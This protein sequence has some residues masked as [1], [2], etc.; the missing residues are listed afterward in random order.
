MN[1]TIRKRKIENGELYSLRL[2]VYPPVL[3]PETGKLVR[4]IKLDMRLYVAPKTIEE[5]QENKDA[6][7]LAKVVRSKTELE[8]QAGHYGFLLKKRDLD[9][10]DFYRK[11]AEKRCC[12]SNLAHNYQSSLGKFLLFVK[13]E[14]FTFSQITKTFIERYRAFLLQDAGLQHNTAALYFS[15]FRTVLNDA[16][17]EGII[18]LRMS[19]QVKSV[20]MKKTKFTYLSYD[21]LDAL[22]HTDCRIGMVK[23][24]ALFSATTGMRFSDIEVLKWE[25]IGHDESGFFVHFSQRKT[26][27][28]NYLPVSDVAI[29]LLGQPG[30][31]LIFPHLRHLHYN[32]LPKAFQEWVVAAGI[33]KP[34]TFHAM[35]HTYATL[36]MMNGTGIKT[37][38][39][40]L[41]HTN[42][43]TTMV[44]AHVVASDKR[45]ASN[46]ISFD[47]KK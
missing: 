12:N 35:R 21:E 26:Q 4:W 30:T 36:L 1:V 9:F 34:V 31:G 13:G 18:A 41:G 25:D 15:L 24:A 20:M 23:I 16:Y 11:V 22:Y 29:E 14:K 33:D 5:R 45:L 47:K 17:R 37:L 3:H 42:I 46:L 6:M 19:E 8:F 10:L 40:L 27:T 44:Y 39:E 43:K 7:A 32:T 28:M 38:S 2:D